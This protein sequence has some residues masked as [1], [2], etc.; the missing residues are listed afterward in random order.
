ML[1]K[2]K[3]AP[4][5]SYCEGNLDEATISYFLKHLDNFNTSKK[6]KHKM[7]VVLIELVSNIII[8][9]DTRYGS[10][11]IMHRNSDFVVNASNFTGMEKV[12]KT[13]ALV[14]EIREKKDPREHYLNMLSGVTYESQVSLG[15]IEIF[16]LCDGNINITGSRIGTKVAINFE[17]KIRDEK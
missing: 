8:H 13:I 9:S 5:E 16:R 12:N 6:V 4:T 7:K 15:L 10:V 14:N 1:K 3:V 11:S 2:N 17:L